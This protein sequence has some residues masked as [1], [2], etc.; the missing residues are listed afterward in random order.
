MA[1][2][3]DSGVGSPRVSGAE[4]YVSGVQGAKLGEDNPIKALFKI[5]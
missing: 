3:G 1:I 2:T 5:M 4:D